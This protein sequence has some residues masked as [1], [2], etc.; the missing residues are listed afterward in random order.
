MSPCIMEHAGLKPCAYYESHSLQDVPR[1]ILW[2]RAEYMLHDVQV[3]TRHI[4]RHEDPAVKTFHVKPAM[5]IQTL[6]CPA[7]LGG[8][9]ACPEGP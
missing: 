2:S 3:Q 8:R 7:K 1:Q 6:A 4:P 9:L 5:P